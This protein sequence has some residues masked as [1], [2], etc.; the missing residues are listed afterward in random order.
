VLTEQQILKAFSVPDSETDTRLADS[1]A[2][3]SEWPEPQPIRATL[4]PV[5][6]FDAYTLLPDPLRVWIMDEA[7]RMPCPPDFIAAVTI[8]T[9]GAI[10][11]ARC[12]IK[13]KA[14]DDWLIVPNV[15]G[16]IVGLPSAKKSP[17]ISTA[18]KPLDRLIAQA[19]ELYKAEME[20]FEAEM[21]IFGAKKEAIES[22]IKSTAKKSN[23]SIGSS[24]DALARELQSF[25]QEAPDKPVLRRF[26]TNDTTVEKLGELLREN[27]T[28]LLVLRDELVGL[29]ASWDREGR[30]GERAFF[31]EAWNG[32][33]SFDTDRIGRGSI[34]V[35]N[36]CV[37][38]FGGI[39]PD[40]LTAYLEQASHALA[41]D[42][43]LQ[44]FQLLVYPDHR[45]WEWRD[46]SP[47]KDARDRAFAMFDTVADFDP[48]A[49]GAVPADDFVKFP[50]FR[51]D[52]AAQEIFIEWSADLHRSKLPAEDFPIVAQH[53]AKFDKL[54]PALA[55]ILHLVDCAAHRK[56]GAVTQAAALRAA[57]W[58][59]YLEAHARRCYGLLTDDGLRAAQALAEKIRQGKL[60]NGFTARDVRRNQWRYLTT[61]EAVQAAL[62]WLTDEIWL[63]VE[64]VG[65][66]GPGSGRQTSRYYINPKAVGPIKS[67][68]D[69][70]E[71]A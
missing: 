66:T 18:L 42:G 49:W 13:P 8:V 16:G 4:Q 19:M 37:S 25:C 2:E 30:E 65:G 48:V 61:D 47:A 15:W 3:T 70:G 31:L 57:A 1:S 11:G 52:E 58:C 62:D 6:P 17:A 29:I 64:E 54:F 69:N 27:P 38:I 41:N 35:P 50:Y 23:G 32:N 40:K 21:T 43:M 56:Q 67:G 28:G 39:Q 24:L 46:R 26:K 22:K 14:K 55:L 68:G 59:D 71:L 7:D 44:R 10:I 5:P 63:R 12:A 36:L 51:F 34:F 53:L 33:Q 20:A 45:E 9:L 60:S